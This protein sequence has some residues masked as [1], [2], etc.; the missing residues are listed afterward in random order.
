MF[1][2]AHSLLILHINLFE[3]SHLSPSKQIPSVANCWFNVKT[4]LANQSKTV[5][6]KNDKK[7]GYILTIKLSETYW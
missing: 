5:S 2:F 7:L 3:I 4:R 1:N 6:K